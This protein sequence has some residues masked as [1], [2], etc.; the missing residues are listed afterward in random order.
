MSRAFRFGR[1][2]VIRVPAVAVRESQGVEVV[3]LVHVSYAANDDFAKSEMGKTY[4]DEQGEFRWLTVHPGGKNHE[5]QVVKI[6]ESKTEKGTWHVVGGAKGK[7]NYL[8]LTG[9]AT[10]AEYAERA[11][12]KRKA[13]TEKKK[14]E[15]ETEHARR[16]SLT[17]D[18]REAERG[19]RQAEKVERDNARKTI[20]EHQREIVEEAA[21][22][23]GWSDDEWKFDREALEK[24]KV[25][26]ARIAQLEREH[27]AVLV[28]RARQSIEAS[29]R[30]LLA[31][32]EVARAWISGAPLRTDDPD[33]VG[34]TDVL[35]KP[36]LPKGKG[37]K[38]ISGEEG[39]RHAQRE[40]AT[41]KGTELRAQLAE[42]EKEAT[43]RHEDGTADDEMAAGIAAVRED[44]HVAELS[45]QAAGMTTAQVEA[46]QGEVTTALQ[47]VEKEHAALVPEL[48]K[49]Q[50]VEEPTAADTAKIEALRRESAVA[51]AQVAALL[52]RATDLAVVKA[53]VE[54]FTLKPEPEIVATER[55]L[56]RK[57][58]VAHEHGAEAAEGYEAR[59]KRMREANDK[60]RKETASLKEKGALKSVKVEPRPTW[61]VTPIS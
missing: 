45:A 2:R 35:D 59:T 49:L 23:F 33:V 48:E 56:R 15:R 13:A 43:A 44:L 1:S 32:G 18:Q 34:L 19:Q 61:L 20:D 27:H 14:S 30:M 26:P 25:Q 38:P 22:A 58:E 50:A 47:A 8:R 60:W 46:E 42:L 52:V 21:E 51:A 6:R 57:A 4:T 7:L 3:E 9:I 16:E 54:K 12:S 10:P 39:E 31:D 5:G 41:R 29:K 11:K 37:Y 36:A 53:T 40:M 17:P 55:M 28:T 24:E